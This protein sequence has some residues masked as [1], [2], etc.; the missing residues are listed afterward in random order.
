MYESD[1]TKFMREFL[2]KHPEEVESQKAGRAAWWDKKP[3]ERSPASPMGHSPRSG[4]NEHTFAV[5]D[6]EKNT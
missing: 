6:E 4:G 3:G 5:P 1:I 2:R